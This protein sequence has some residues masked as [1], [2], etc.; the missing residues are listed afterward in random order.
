MWCHNCQWRA[1]P[2]FALCRWLFA[3]DLEADTPSTCRRRRNRRYV[4]FYSP[5]GA[6]WPARAQ[7]HGM[8]CTSCPL[9]QS[10]QYA[11]WGAQNWSRCGRKGRSSLG[12]LLAYQPEL[13]H[14]NVLPV[15]LKDSPW[16]SRRPERNC[17]PGRHFH[18]PARDISGGWSSFGAWRGSILSRTRP[19]RWGMEWIMWL[20]G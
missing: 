7:V 15:R 8:D 10:K 11:R 13:E 4:G 3:G 14:S 12:S 19:C 6:L 17:G 9:W 20:V 1:W 18:L 16:S 2:S 5:G